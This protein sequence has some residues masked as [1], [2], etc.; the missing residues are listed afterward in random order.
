[1]KQIFGN[2]VAG[3]AAFGL[4]VFRLLFG[5]GIALHGY[6]KVISPGG[7]FGWADEG[8]RFHIPPLFQAC[9][10]LAELGGGIGVM[11]GLL[12]PVAAGGIVIT[13]SV[14]ILKFHWA[15]RG[16]HYVAITPGFD[17]EAAGHYFILALGLLF[18]GPGTISLDMLIFGRRFNDPTYMP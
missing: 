8:L 1:M 16:A 7:P 17:Y 6:Q 11:L 13:M 2:F 10:T 15:V 12:T 3:R 9:A 14:A 4:L 5:I 18:T